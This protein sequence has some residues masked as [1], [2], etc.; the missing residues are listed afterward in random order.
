[1]IFNRGD[2]LSEKSILHIMDVIEQQQQKIEELE[3]KLSV[4]TG[5]GFAKEIALLKSLNLTA[6]QIASRY[7]KT[8]NSK[9]GFSTSEIYK[10]LGG[11][12]NPK[13]ITMAEFIFSKL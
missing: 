11:T 13:E 9:N 10:H 6:R 12:G 2:V 4:V 5:K 8:S 1:M 3:K 7:Y